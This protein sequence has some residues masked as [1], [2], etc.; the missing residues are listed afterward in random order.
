LSVGTVR[1]GP[2]ALATALG[3]R[4]PSAALRW[5]AIVTAFGLF[6]VVVLG[7]L[8]TATNSAL[9]CGRSFPLCDGRLFPQPTLTSIVEWTHRV[10]SAFVG[11]LV[12]ALAVWAWIEART[13]PFVRAL[14]V[15]GLGFLV[16][17]SAV[18]AAA[19]LWPEPRAVIAL[20][21]GIALTSFGAIAALALV[22][23][24][25]G[26]APDGG[27][28]AV[29]GAIRRYLWLTLVYTYAIVYL[30]A[31]VAQLDAG[32]VCGTWPLCAG[33]LVPA[34]FTL[35][36]AV[37]YVHRLAAVG[38]L[39]LFAGLVRVARPLRDGGH[40]GLYRAAHLAF[41]L[42][43]LLTLSGLYLVLSHVALV[44]TMIHVALVTLLF[45]TV[46]YMCVF[47]LPARS[48]PDVAAAPIR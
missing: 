15:I 34:H 22:L 12:L 39:A 43:V 17:E 16:V 42:V 21:L 13:S 35:P 26:A 20:H 28:G 7:F 19:V 10:V 30:G 4:R 27:G 5:F 24:R 11:V 14:A 1:G 33:A 38:A 41:G 36:L 48:R 23:Q 18:G 6:A 31:L 8:D 46:S 44:A 40:R 3:P 47:S 9:G 29:G 2:P 25:P 45:G 37:D 32:P